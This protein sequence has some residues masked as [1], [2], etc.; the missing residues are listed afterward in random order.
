MAAFKALFDQL[1][2]AKLTIKSGWCEFARA[3]VTYLSRVVGQGRVAP[4]HAKMSAVEQ[5]PQPT[6]KRNS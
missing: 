5:F 2:E 6:T 1:A 4:V 3:A